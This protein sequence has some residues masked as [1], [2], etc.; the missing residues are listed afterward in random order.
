MQQ[1]A[2]RRRFIVA[3]AGTSLAANGC[4]ESPTEVVKTAPTPVVQGTKIALRG[5]QIVAMYV[6]E[7]LVRLP[8]TAVRVLGVCL[9]ISSFG[10]EL[11]VDYLD[12]ELQQRQFREVLTEEQKITIEGKRSV[13]L[14]LENGQQES[15]PLG[16]NQYSKSQKKD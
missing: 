9:V 3:M 8:H 2:S 13:K 16:D 1:I 7:K 15:V 12:D 10:A 11:V 14:V 4:G 6:G 5:Y